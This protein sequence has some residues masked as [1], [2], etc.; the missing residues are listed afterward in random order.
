VT[1]LK[2]NILSH[3]PLGFAYLFP[4]SSLWMLHRG[5]VNDQHFRFSVFLMF[6]VSSSYS[7]MVDGTANTATTTTKLSFS[8]AFGVIKDDMWYGPIAVFRLPECNFFHTPA[9]AMPCVIC[10]CVCLCVCLRV[11]VC[12]SVRSC[13]F[14]CILLCLGFCWCV[15]MC[16]WLCLHVVVCVYVHLCVLMYVRVS[17]SVFLS[18]SVVFVLGGFTE[19]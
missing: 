12:V 5:C 10:V 2:F 7:R 16:V 19:F 11:F 13:T 9:C 8:H 4:M 1:Y 6:L 14:V 18:V 15:F 17:S 3:K